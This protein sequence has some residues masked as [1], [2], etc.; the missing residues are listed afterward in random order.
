MMMRDF[1]YPVGYKDYLEYY[2]PLPPPSPN[3]PSP[4]RVVDEEN[5][6]E[7]RSVATNIVIKL[8]RTLQSSH[9]WG[10]YVFYPTF[11][12]G[13]AEPLPQQGLLTSQSMD[14]QVL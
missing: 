12:N 11:K 2:Q 6:S 3:C 10:A 5:Y 9:F 14:I 1:V 7:T 13:D 8:T 4:E